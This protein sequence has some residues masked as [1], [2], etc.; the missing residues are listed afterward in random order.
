MSLI[1][2]ASVAL[3]LLPLCAMLMAGAPRSERPQIPAHG[4]E[5]SGD[6]LRQIVKDG[7][8]LFSEELPGKPWPR[9]TFFRQI[10]AL[11]EEAFAVFSDV[12]SES[13]YIPGILESR[14]SR[15]LNASTVEVRYVQNMPW[16]VQNETMTIL[17]WKER[18]GTA[19]TVNWKLL[20]AT[21]ARAANGFAS[22]EPWSN[23]TLMIYQTWVD[24]GYDIAEWPLVRKVAARRT[25]EVTRLFEQQVYKVKTQRPADLARLQVES[26]QG[27][28]RP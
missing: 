21:S 22:F 4:G 12:E 14:I 18:R 11:P 23:I 1:H 20:S 10:R 8:L 24:P 26:L 3:F 15:R 27:I 6:Q 16:P 9:L 13:T 25:G 19:L 28:G 7:F 2:R 5:L 17:N